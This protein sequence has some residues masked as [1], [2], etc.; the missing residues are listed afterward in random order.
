MAT[1]Y[2]PL[3]QCLL[4]ALDRFPSSR[5]QMYRTSAGW[6]T[7]S[8]EELLRRIA[9]IA[10]AL[11]ELGVGSGDRVAVFAANCPEWHVADFAIQGIGGVTVPVYFHE[12][13]D[14]IT[15]ILKDSGAR[16][17]FTSGEEQARKI[18]ECRPE[19]ARARTSDFSRA[20]SRP[21]WRESSLRRADRGDGRRGDPGVSSPDG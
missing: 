10:K 6:K 21:A 19:P 5:A 1:E 2:P 4:D 18:A 15:Y 8:S 16:V 11:A 12:S 9:G 14:R 13:V 7:I 3:P 17:V 20:A